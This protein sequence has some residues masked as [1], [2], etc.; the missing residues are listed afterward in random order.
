MGLLLKKRVEGSPWGTKWRHRNPL[1]LTDAEVDEMLA[2]PDPKD[3]G[4]DN[5]DEHVRHRPG[6]PMQRPWR[7]V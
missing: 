2:A 7:V 1:N 6:A 4:T 3:T 5:E